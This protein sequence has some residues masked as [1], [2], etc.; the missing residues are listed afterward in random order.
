MGTL[1]GAVGF[2]RSPSIATTGC[3]DMRTTAFTCGPAARNVVSRK[4]VMPAR[5]VQRIDTDHGP[6]WDGRRPVPSWYKGS[7]PSYGSCPM[8]CGLRLHPTQGV[9]D[10]L[11]L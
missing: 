1:H 4:T 11:L 8:W 7:R 5:Q 2:A 10:A 6:R 9:H 3:S